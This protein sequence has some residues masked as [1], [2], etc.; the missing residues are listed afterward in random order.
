M[1]ALWM[2]KGFARVLVPLLA[3]ICLLTAGCADETGFIDFTRPAQTTAPPAGE[4]PLVIVFAPV[5]S[6]EETRRPYERI[7]EHIA[8]KIDRPV[9]MVQ[10]R[11]AG[12]L[13]QLVAAGEADVAFLS[14]GAYT[15]YRGQEPI[16]LL[17]MVETRGTVLYRTY[18]IVAADSPI[19][20]FAQLRIEELAAGCCGMSGNYGFK[21]DTYD[22]SMKV[23]EALFRRIEEAGTD[24]VV[25]DCGTCRMQIR[26]GSGKRTCHPIEVLAQAYGQ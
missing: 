10:K 22:V 19:E 16:E 24:T 5:M 1:M 2:C 15:A 21:G 23:G 12:E 7:A 11:S 14:T 26:H 3:A 18:V 6:P 25:S 8:D 9:V 17:A 20:N 4:K 13:D